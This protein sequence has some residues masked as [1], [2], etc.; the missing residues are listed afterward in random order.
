MEFKILKEEIFDYQDKDQLCVMILLIG[1]QYY[2]EVDSRSVHIGRIQSRSRKEAE[3]MLSQ[4]SERIQKL[5]DIYEAFDI[6]DLAFQFDEVRP[7]MFIVNNLDS[8]IEFNEIWKLKRVYGCQ[9]TPAI[10][11]LIFE[12]KS[13]NK[14]IYITFPGFNNPIGYFK[15]TEDSRESK[16]R[17]ELSSEFLYY[18]S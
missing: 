13:Y 7:F 15:A 3:V 2:I 17:F 8:E 11:D 14:T 18:T 5:S 9:T 12:D 16:F 6:L 1:N 10:T 4:I